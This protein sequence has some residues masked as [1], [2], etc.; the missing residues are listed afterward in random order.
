[1]LTRNLKMCCIHWK[2]VLNKEDGSELYRSGYF[3][4]SV[5]A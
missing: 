1:M 3:Y 5:G 2:K 4:L